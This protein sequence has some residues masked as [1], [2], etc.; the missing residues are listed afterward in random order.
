MRNMLYVIPAAAGLAF[1]GT[2]HAADAPIYEIVPDAVVYQEMASSWDG[3][4]VGV[5]GGYAI[6]EF[7]STVVGG[8]DP[9]FDAEGYVFGAQIGYDVQN[10]NFVL[11]VVGD[12]SFT[13]IDATTAGLGV[14]G[15][16][17]AEVDWLAT[18]RGRFGYAMGNF[19]PYITGGVAFAGVT[20]TLATVS[21]DAVHMG[22]TVGGGIEY[23]LG[24]GLTLGGE[25]LYMDLGEE[26][27][28]YGAILIDTELELHV[29]R[30]SL[31]YRFNY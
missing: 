23:A 6:G 11:G 17:S 14:L 24:N 22:W 5:H 9:P 3:F 1:M 25:Y 29:A 18:V 20:T 2:A 30:A 26:R 31:N 16:Y 4:Y 15:Q 7:N 10:G 8:I 21:D 12:A 28:A 27:Y 19:L 13:T